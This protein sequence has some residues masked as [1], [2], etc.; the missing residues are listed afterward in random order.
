MLVATHVA[1]LERVPPSA[2]TELVGISVYRVGTALGGISREIY[3]A[4]TGMED[5]ASL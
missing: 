3:K 4:E 5:T 1:N 2:H